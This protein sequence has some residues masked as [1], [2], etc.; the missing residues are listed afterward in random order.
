MNAKHGV[1]GVEEMPSKQPSV[2]SKLVTHNGQ[3]VKAP[4]A[5]KQKVTASKQKLAHFVL[6]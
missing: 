5:P 1:M 2:I 3:Q 6:T 4:A